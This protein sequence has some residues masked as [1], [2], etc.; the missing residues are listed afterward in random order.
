M[1]MTHTRR[2]GRLYRYYVSTAVLKQGRGA[3]PIGR[4]P[5]GEVEAAV[6]SQVRRLLTTP[7][8]IV[9]TWRAARERDG[10]MTEAEVRTALT[11]LD[12][13]WEELFPAE[14]A[15]IVQLLVERVEVSSNG[16]ELALRTAGLT[17][18]VQDLRAGAH[19]EDRKAA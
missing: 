9:R 8:I 3:C 12:P 19:N 14:Q 18:L 17:S 7:E 11:E 5:A 15:R 1:V 6:I 10:G 16:I 4:V 2:R 13:L